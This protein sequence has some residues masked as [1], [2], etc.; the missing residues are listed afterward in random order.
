MHAY[1][2]AWDSRR[3]I[4][5][6]CTGAL[7]QVGKPIL[8]RHRIFI[9]RCTLGTDKSVYR[10]LRTYGASDCAIRNTDNGLLSMHLGR[11][12]WKSRGT[13]RERSI[14]VPRDKG[15]SINKENWHAFAF[16]RLVVSKDIF[17]YNIFINLKLKFLFHLSLIFLIIFNNN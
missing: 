7:C 10:V 17:L 15:S 14:G 16:S 13:V 6:V 3:I 12:D 4:A 2:C 9:P 8:K 11:A 5:R 1:I